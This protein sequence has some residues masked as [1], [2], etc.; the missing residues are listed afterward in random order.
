L[1]DHEPEEAVGQHHQ[2]PVA[3]GT[4][5]KLDLTVAKDEVLLVVL[6]GCLDPPTIPYEGMI[7]TPG[8]SIFVQ[9]EVGDGASFSAM[10]T[11]CSPIFDTG[12]FFVQ[13]R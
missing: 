10:M 5:I 12:R 3:A 13:I 7:L 6:E 8:V 1:Q 2:L 4:G 11:R 9:N